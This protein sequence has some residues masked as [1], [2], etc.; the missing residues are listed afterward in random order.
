VD[1]DGTKMPG[2]SNFELRTLEFS[3]PR[4]GGSGPKR[5]IYRIVTHSYDLQRLLGKSSKERRFGLNLF[6]GLA[7]LP[8][9]VGSGPDG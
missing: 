9:L 6:K 5:Q 3:P 1:V 2:T 8:F 4:S 7:I